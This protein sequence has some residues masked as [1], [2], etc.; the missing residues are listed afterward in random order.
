MATRYY[1]ADASGNDDGT[2]EANAYETFTTALEALDAGDILYLKKSSSR[3]AVVGATIDMKVATN[4]AV[5]I[6]EGYSV[7]PGDGIRW[8]GDGKIIMEDNN[9]PGNIIFKNIDMTAD[10]SFVWKNTND[11]FNT[12]FYNCKFHNT[13]TTV[14]RPAFIIQHPCTFVNCYFDADSTSSTSGTVYLF[15]YDHSIFIG[16]VIR[17]AVGIYDT[18]IGA[19]ALTVQNCIF[20][21]GSS[22]AMV[23]GLSTDLIVGTSEAKQFTVSQSVFYG[24]SK[25]AI[26]IRDLPPLTDVGT[27]TMISNNIFYGAASS[28]TQRD[29]IAISDTSHTVGPMIVGNAYGVVDNQISGGGTNFPN[30][31]AVTLTADPFENGAALDFRLN[32]AAGGGAL[33]KGTAYPT[34]FQGIAGAVERNIGALQHTKESISIF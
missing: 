30:F 4:T 1:Y 21:D 28:L 34:T 24:F 12:H 14:N 20:T 17:G 8:Q 27:L 29:A 18:H 25:D 7:T 15:G 3:V 22:Q 13:S 6:V 23:T 31:D 33:C 32:G 26:E 16:C 10:D 19:S 9:V 2:S 5:T 11:I